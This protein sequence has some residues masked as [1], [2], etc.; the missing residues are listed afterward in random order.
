MIKI[1][2]FLVGAGEARSNEIRRL[3]KHYYTRKS[4]TFLRWRK[5]TK[6]PPAL[7]LSPPLPLSLSL[8]LSLSLARARAL[9]LLWVSMTLGWG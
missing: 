9:V 7:S 5:G 4:K 2:G 8:S 1:T 3:E 6:S